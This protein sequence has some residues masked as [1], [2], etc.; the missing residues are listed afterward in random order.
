[1]GVFFFSFLA[2]TKFVVGEPNFTRK[3]IMT[4]CLPLLAIGFFLSAD[5]RTEIVFPT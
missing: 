1:M 5:A 4:L 3:A 2:T